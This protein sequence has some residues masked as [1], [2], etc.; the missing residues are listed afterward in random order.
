MNERKTISIE[1]T[2]LKRDMN[3]KGLIETNID[4]AREYENRRK[5]L[6]KKFDEKDDRIG[7]LEGQIDQLWAAINKLIEKQT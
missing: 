3:S 2:T 7:Q 5:N 6:K 1:G 4:K